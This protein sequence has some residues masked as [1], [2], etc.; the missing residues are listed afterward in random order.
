MLEKKIL[1]VGLGLMGG[2][3]AEAL[4]DAGFEVGAVDKRREAIDYARNKGI[5]AKGTT[6]L[7]KGFFAGY[8]L[9]VFCLYP[10]VLVK[11]IEEHQDIIAPG[12]LITDTSGV[13]APIVYRIQQ[14]LRPDLE[15]VGSHPMAGRERSGVENSDCSV[16]KGA[17]YLV[18]PTKANTPEAIE[19]CKELGRILGF[20]KVSELS[21]EEH[22]EMIGFLSQLTHCIAVSLMTCRD[23]S[24]MAM[25]SGDSF[26]DLTRIAA[27]NEVMWNELF[28][29]NRDIL[30]KQIDAFV[31][32]MEM[33]KEAIRD[34]DSVFLKD[35]MKKSSAKRESFEKRTI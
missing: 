2:S 19:T 6:E 1:I 34:G 25:Y 14:T 15:F 3:Y 20:G 17:N 24:R 29:L 23:T 28:L 7:D 33:L 8:S 27:I 12:T 31:D 18:T 32:R 13:K 16:F 10:T 4:T 5:I 26:R 30:V 11:W 22:D 21:P 35:A 9:I